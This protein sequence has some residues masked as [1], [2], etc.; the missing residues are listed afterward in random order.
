LPYNFLWIAQIK[1]ITLPEIPAAGSISPRA[2]I[3]PAGS[4]ELTGTILLIP[5][6]PEIM[7]PSNEFPLLM[8]LANPKPASNNITF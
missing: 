3:K 6:D 1:L 2:L 4:V 7:L 5:D 8:I